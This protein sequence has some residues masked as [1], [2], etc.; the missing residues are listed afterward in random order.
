MNRNKLVPTLAIL[1]LAGAGALVFFN[2]RNDAGPEQPDTGG[3]A[4]GAEASG[5]G[6]SAGG[7]SGPSAT[8]AG[9]GR[10]AGRADTDAL[11]EKYGESRTNLSR[12]VAGTLVTLLDD[13]VYMGETALS[14]DQGP[15]SNRTFALR[16]GLGGGLLD[17]LALDESQQARAEEA[18]REFQKR[19]LERT[20]IAAE[21]LRNDPQPLMRL[22][23]ASD[24]F[25]RGEIAEADYRNLEQAAKA[26]LD[27]VMNPLDRMNFQGGRPLEDERFREDMLGVLE[28]EQA[29]AFQAAA[30]ERA[31]GP[32]GSITEMSAMNLEQVDQAI[33]A[34]QRVTS[35]VRQMMEGMGD[36]QQLGPMLEQQ[37]PRREQDGE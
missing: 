4:A 22:L 9:G 23:L 6:R 25:S 10:Q 11:A 28:P 20:K 16:A 15:F 3:A 32:T 35:G 17:E 33:T 1:L 13:A 7:A 12:H 18:F 14:S 8:G 36:L 19:E 5:T 21:S 29:E 26:E 31:D 30:E 34:A 27:G 24:A 37:R 2:M